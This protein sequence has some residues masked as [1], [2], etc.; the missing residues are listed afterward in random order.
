VSAPF[1]RPSPDRPR[2][3]SSEEMPMAS[4]RPN[5]TPRPA[6]QWLRSLARDTAGAALLEI[7]LFMPILVL[8]AVA[9]INFGF[10][11]L[12][13][14]Q[15]VNA[16]QAGAQW[17]TTNAWQK[18]AYSPSSIQSAG[19]GANNSSLPSV[20]A[21]ISVPTISITQVCLCPSSS[22]LT[23]STATAPSCANGP[24]CSND[25]S[26][27]GYYIKVV[28]SGTFTPF[29]NYGSFFPSSFNL[30]STVTVRVQ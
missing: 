26:V 6:L 9:I 22:G 17:A 29:S 18:N 23:S 5:L 15:V 27:P 30:S 25:G 3:S 28:A 2:S 24:V 14:I 21:A 11:F 16:A 7:T 13:Q 4:A 8:I 12:Y 19:T 20:F 10:Y 1:R